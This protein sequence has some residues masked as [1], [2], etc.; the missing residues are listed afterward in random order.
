MLSVEV[1]FDLLWIITCKRAN[2]DPLKR[3]E[4]L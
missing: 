3:N 2:G 1:G 4:K